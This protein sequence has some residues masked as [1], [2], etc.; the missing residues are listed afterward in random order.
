MTF[1]KSVASKAVAAYLI[2]V[3]LVVIDTAFLSWL[4]DVPRS[5]CL[6]IVLQSWI[7][8]LWLTDADATSRRGIEGHI[9]FRLVAFVA[10]AAVVRPALWLLG[11]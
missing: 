7:A 11:G 10:V 8:C 9:L 4:L 3:S 2:A 1:A 6:A 5:L